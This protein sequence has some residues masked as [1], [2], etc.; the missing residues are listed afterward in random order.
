MTLIFTTTFRRHSEGRLEKLQKSSSLLNLLAAA[1]A[2]G[3]L[4]RKSAQE[5]YAA[6]VTSVFCTF[7]VAASFFSKTFVGNSENR[8]I[9]SAFQ[10]SGFS[11]YPPCLY[12]VLGLLPMTPLEFPRKGAGFLLPS[13]QRTPMIFRPSPGSLHRQS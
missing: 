3:T 1:A 10:D 11:I 2:L 8:I 5:T 13:T 12:P 4:V 9:V 6:I 7:E